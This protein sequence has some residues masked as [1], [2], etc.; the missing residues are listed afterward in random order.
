MKIDCVW[1]PPGLGREFEGGGREDREGGSRP[2]AD[3]KSSSAPNALPLP[4]QAERSGSY[5]AL[6]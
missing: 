2:R 5:K 6:H 4:V 1:E 3:Y